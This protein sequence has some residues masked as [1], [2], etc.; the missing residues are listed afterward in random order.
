MKTVQALLCAVFLCTTFIS[1]A[2]C[3]PAVVSKLQTV[4]VDKIFD[5][6][7]FS[8]KD[9]RKVRLLGINTP[10]TGYYGKA[11]ESFSQKARKKLANLIKGKTVQ[12]KI[13]K[14]A[15][16]KYSR[17]LANV[18]LNDNTNVSAKMLESGLGYLLIIPP[19]VEFADCYKRAQTRA[20]VAQLNLFGGDYR[21][22]FS[23]KIGKLKKIK[24]TRNSIWLYLDNKKYVR[25]SREDRQYFAKICLPCMIGKKISFQGWWHKSKNGLRLR[26][27]HPLMMDI[28]E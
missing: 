18:F 20:K 13:G 11:G 10:E 15:Q 27:Y 8:L 7:T 5:G 1:Y 4:Q 17:V 28:N 21:L 23:R 6:D 25:I 14:P 9:G 26:L 3:Y 19:N 24:Q 12:L 2:D 22:K 16:D